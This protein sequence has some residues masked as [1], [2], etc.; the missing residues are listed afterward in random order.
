MLATYIQDGDVFDYTPA[1]ALPAGAVVVLGV[2][3]GVAP[4]PIPA[5][6]LGSLAVEGV[7]AFPTTPGLAGGTGI[8]VFWDAIANLATIDGTLN[9]QLVRCGVLARP[10]AAADGDLHVLINR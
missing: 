4:R 8:P 6:T 3:V 5:G 2:F 10:L 9:T 7:F 1:A